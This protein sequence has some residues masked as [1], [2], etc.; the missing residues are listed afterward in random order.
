MDLLAQFVALAA[1]VF[2]LGLNFLDGTI[3]SDALISEGFKLVELLAQLLLDRVAGLL[4]INHVAA[5]LDHICVNFLNLC[6]QDLNFFVDL[7]NLHVVGDV[8][9]F[10]E[11][12]L[13]LF[14]DDS[15]F[16]YV[17]LGEALSSAPL[18][19][20]ILSIFA[21]ELGLGRYEGF[22]LLGERIKVF[23]LLLGIFLLLLIFKLLTLFR[24]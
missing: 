20:H 5:L 8:V 15:L 11:D 6:L 16:G 9:G 19:K 14:R 17:D 22:V 3:N 21:V 18:T 12:L 13:W 24:C 2:D 1:E 4:S 23:L 7:G 10:S